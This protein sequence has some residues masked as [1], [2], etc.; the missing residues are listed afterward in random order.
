MRIKFMC[1]NVWNGGKIWEPMLQFL[2]Q[3]QP[4]ILALQEVYTDGDVDHLPQT[5]LLN[6]L[7]TDF[8]LQY[9]SHAPAFVNI[10]NGKKVVKGNAI[11][12]RFPIVEAESKHFDTPFCEMDDS[13]AEGQDYTH[14]PRN[15]QRVLV[16]LEEKQLHVFNTQGI[17]GFDGNDTPRRLAMVE[18]ILTEVG[19]KTPVILTGDFNVDQV[20]Q[21]IHNIENRLTNI[22]KGE[23]RTT[24]NM[25]QKKSQGYATAVVDFIFV[26]ADIKVMSHS[27]PDVDVTDH[28]PLIAEFEV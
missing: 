10:H 1:L 8:G 12:S 21:S 19:D 24:F 14:I 28:L 7:K 20:S 27:C 16:D 22:F 18:K 5:T 6:V 25:R 15:W 3:Q 26:S 17:W 9:M 13:G 4:D 23:L 11:A 2:R